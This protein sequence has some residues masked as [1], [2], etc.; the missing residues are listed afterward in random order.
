MYTPSCFLVSF[1][2]EPTK[3]T[4]VV[5]RSLLL[6]IRNGKTK[7]A[8]HT[9][10]LPSTCTA[11]EASSPPGTQGDAG[12]DWK[13]THSRVL[14]AWWTRSF[15]IVGGWPE[16]LR[17]GNIP[18]SDSKSQRHR[19]PSPCDKQNILTWFLKLP[20]GT[21]P[22]PIENHLRDQRWYPGY[23]V[24]HKHLFVHSL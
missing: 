4:E 13:R 7:E 8:P 19:P 17:V 23:C 20:A 11:L 5:K 9:E 18:C 24:C 14:S 2:V 3:P 6:V 10:T 15:F 22:P 21:K 12:R 1:R 16:R